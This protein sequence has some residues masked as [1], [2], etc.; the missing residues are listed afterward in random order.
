[1]C[2]CVCMYVCVGLCVCPWM[3]GQGGDLISSIFEAAQSVK[4]SCARFSLSSCNSHEHTYIH[5]MPSSLPVFTV[6]NPCLSSFHPLCHFLKI[7][8]QPVKSPHSRV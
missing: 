2:A 8:V 1:M 6:L 5:R 7:F 3:G 4:K